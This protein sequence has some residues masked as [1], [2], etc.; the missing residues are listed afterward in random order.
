MTFQASIHSIQTGHLLLRCSVE[1]HDLREAEHAAILRAAVKFS[2]LPREM[3][4]RHLHQCAERANPEVAET[5][6]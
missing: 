4:V 1:G 2:G 3:D 6:G 5:R